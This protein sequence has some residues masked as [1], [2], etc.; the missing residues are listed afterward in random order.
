M[1]NFKTILNEIK[2]GPE[3]D[4]FIGAHFGS[5]PFPRNVE[6]KQTPDHLRWLRKKLGDDLPFTYGVPDAQHVR[7]EYLPIVGIHDEGEHTVIKLRANSYVEDL[8]KYKTSHAQSTNIQSFSDEFTHPEERMYG[9][10][11]SHQEMTEHLAKMVGLTG[12]VEKI[13]LDRGSPQEGT[14]S[15]LHIHIPRQHIID[16]HNRRSP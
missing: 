13:T 7:L 4:K 9:P 16:A 3:W 5:E 14:D 11:S 12:R 2:A 1:K 6:I 15:V 10:V 8:N